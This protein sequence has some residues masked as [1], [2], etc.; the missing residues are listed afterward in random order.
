MG[1][2]VGTSAAIPGTATQ[3]SSMPIAP[4]PADNTTLSVSTW[5]AMR[6]GRAP[7]ATRTASSRCRCTARASSRLARFAQAMSSTHAEAPAR[8]SS[9]K[10]DCRDTSS[11]SSMTV[12]PVRSLASGKARARPSAITFNS[13]RAWPIVTPGASRP[14]PCR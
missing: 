13:A 14:M 11:R 4:P 10:R 3:A 8:A 9:I 12:A 1:N 6:R 7:I 2:D 5:R